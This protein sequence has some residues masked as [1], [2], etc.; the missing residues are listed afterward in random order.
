VKEW[1]KLVYL[2]QS[3]RKNKSGVPLILDRSVYYRDLKTWVKCHS[4]SLKVVPFE[5][6]GKVSYSPSLVTMVASAAILEIFS[7]KECP[8]LVIRVWGR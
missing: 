2:Y 4:R 6:L 3:Y 8:D 5:S 1:L 7:I